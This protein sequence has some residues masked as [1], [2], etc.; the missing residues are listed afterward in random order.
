M[1]FSE[2]SAT[3]PQ[4][5]MLVPLIIVF[6][7]AGL[8]INMIFGERFSEKTI[9]TIASSAAGLAFVVAV[10]QAIS[11]ISHPEGQ[12]IPIVNWIMTGE[13]NLHWGFQ[14]DTLSVTMMLVV[15][16][17]GTTDNLILQEIS[18]EIR[19]KKCEIGK[20]VR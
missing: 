3:G 17:V 12:V 14:V 1:L 13:V 16:G 9:G 10:L 19:R 15:S 11:L 18:E 20:N 8:L 5:F 4:F 2:V 6:P 7:L